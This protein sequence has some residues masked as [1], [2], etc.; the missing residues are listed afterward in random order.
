MTKTAAAFAS[1]V[2]SNQAVFGSWMEI[3]HAM[4]AETLAQT[5]VDFLLVDGEHG[6]TPPHLLLD[7]LPGADRFGVPAIYRVAWNRP[8]YI[9]AALDAGAAGIMIPMINSADE[10]AAA[11]AG[12]K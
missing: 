2:K 12:A 9:K 10:A 8:E 3:P 1:R 6:P 7:I 5:G 4:V 11:V